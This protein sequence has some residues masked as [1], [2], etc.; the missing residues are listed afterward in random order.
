VSVAGV[1]LGGVVIVAL[2]VEGGHGVLGEVAAVRGLPLVVHVGEHGP[3]ESNHVGLVGEDSDDSGSALDL[4]V[5]P[6]EGVRGPDLGPV[7][8]RDPVKARTEAP[9]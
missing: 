9:R 3:D 4:F 8:S 7:G 6:L 2:G 1:E 5:D